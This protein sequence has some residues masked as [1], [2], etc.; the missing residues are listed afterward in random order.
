MPTITEI[1][2]ANKELA[3]ARERAELRIEFAKAALIGF[4]SNP[5]FSEWDVDQTAHSSWAQ[6]DAMLE[7]MNAPASE[8]GE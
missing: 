6:A 3:D 5:D 4:L 1:A 7:A 8:T 2:Q